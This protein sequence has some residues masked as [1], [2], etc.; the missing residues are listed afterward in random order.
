MDIKKD[1]VVV[2][3]D[4]KITKKP[5]RLVTYALGSCVGVAIYD[6]KNYIGG[7]AHVLLPS[8]NL[9]QNQEKAIKYADIAVPKLYK[10]LIK[11]GAD[12]ESL[13]AKIAGG[14]NMF[15]KTSHIS[16]Y[17]I[18]K[19]NVAIVK[20]K[21]KELKVP[22]IAEDTGGKN[23]RTMIL[24]LKTLQIEIKSYKNDLSEMTLL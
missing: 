5:N 20:K 22:L 18:G 14:A 19:S 13:R 12:K 4:I 8:S 21:L 1:I 23:S 15:Y 17:D 11:F 10:D 24:D 9:F 3:S 6:I 7:L 2:I 16:F